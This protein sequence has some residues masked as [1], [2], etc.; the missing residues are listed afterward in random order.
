MEL[1]EI[2]CEVQ[3]QALVLKQGWL[4]GRKSLRSE[5]TGRSRCVDGVA[6]EKKARQSSS[7]KREREC[8]CV[9]FGIECVS[10][11]G[12]ERTK[13]VCKVECNSRRYVDW[14]SGQVN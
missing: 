2:S 14:N 6:W 10:S 3:V 9:G 8:V 5:Q 12:G 1:E 13:E 4:G 7:E 11:G